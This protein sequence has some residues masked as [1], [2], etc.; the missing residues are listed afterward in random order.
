[1][2]V[3][4]VGE[5][6]GFKIRDVY[7]PVII[8]DERSILFYSTE[9]ILPRAQFFNLPKGDYFVQ[10]GSF[11]KLPKPIAYSL[12]RL[13]PVQRFFYPSTK[14]FQIEIVKNPHKCSIDWESRKILLDE[15]FRDKPWPLIDFILSHE[16]GHKYYGDK[17]NSELCADYFAANRMIKKGYNPLQIGYAQ[18]DSLSGR[19]IERKNLLINK[20]INSYESTRTRM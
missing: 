1:M 3:L 19:Q 14:N 12:I 8:R 15:S 17:E 9:D 10:S 6:T 7:K 2:R 5:K 4:I 18:L 20:L 11:E 13:P 16:V